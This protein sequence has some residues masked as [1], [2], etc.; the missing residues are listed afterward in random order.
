[1]TGNRE[2]EEEEEEE[3]EATKQ[4]TL[5]ERM[6]G[7]A[8]VENIVANLFDEVCEDELL[9]SFSLTLITVSCEKLKTPKTTFFLLMISGLLSLSNRPK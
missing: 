4:A 8:G 2:E 6:G 1:M 7:D 9:L 5:Y 3:E